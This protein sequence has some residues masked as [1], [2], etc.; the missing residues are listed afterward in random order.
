MACCHKTSSH[1]LTGCSHRLDSEVDST[2]TSRPMALPIFT[3]LEHSKQAGGR[4]HAGR[5]PPRCNQLPGQ[6]QSAGDRAT[7]SPEMPLSGHR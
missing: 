4:Q 1:S 7:S 5:S 2:V 6:E 3:A